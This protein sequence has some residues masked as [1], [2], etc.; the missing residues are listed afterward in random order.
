LPISIFFRIKETPQ[1]GSV[2]TMF[3]NLGLAQRFKRGFI[4]FNGYREADIII[5]GADDE[6]NAYT[7]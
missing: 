5:S 1:H 3:S 6:G 7:S 4:R 2:F